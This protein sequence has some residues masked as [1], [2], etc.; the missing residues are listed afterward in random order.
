M[1]PI[2][3]RRRTSS[4]I[5]IKV[6]TCLFAV[7]SPNATFALLS[8]ELNVTCFEQEDLPFSVVRANFV[9]R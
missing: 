3:D 5:C 9:A 1:V 7:S 8:S 4:S 6:G 2:T